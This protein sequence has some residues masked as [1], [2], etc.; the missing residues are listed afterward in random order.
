MFLPSTDPLWYD[1]V[2]RGLSFLTCDVQMLV[3]SEEY[4]VLAHSMLKG[5]NAKLAERISALEFSH[6][7]VK[8]WTWDSYTSFTKIMDDP[9]AYGFKDATTYGNGTDL[10][11]G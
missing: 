8:T 11:W 6:G 1:L 4:R 10:F 5:Y 2:S 3:Q 7:D 9:T